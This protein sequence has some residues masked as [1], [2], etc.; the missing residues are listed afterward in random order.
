MNTTL[1]IKTYA[2]PFTMYVVAGTYTAPPST[3]PTTPFS[4]TIF[5]NSQPT[6]IGYQTLTAVSS[7]LSVSLQSQGSPVVNVNTSYVFSVTI[8]D[9]LTTSGKFKII[10]PSQVNILATSSAC[11]S[12]LGSG[13]ASSPICTINTS[14]NTIELSSINSTSS[15]I[16]AQP[17]T[18]TIFGIQNPSS[19]IPSGTFQVQSYNQ[20][21]D[22]SLVAV[23][24]TAAGVTATQGAIDPASVTIT[25]SS[26]K[27]LDQ[28]ATYSITL[29]AVNQVLMGGY[30]YIFIPA[31]IVINTNVLASS[32]KRGLNSAATQTTACTLMTQDSTGYLINF[33][34]P[35]STSSLNVGSSIT[36]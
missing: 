11:A 4:F 28:S 36:F 6:Q 24:T 21:T 35:L 29:I 19:I 34:T 31:P 14:T 7:T 23:G 15:A 18:L 5:R 30:F 16:G 12:M 13:L 26:Y 9:G 17:F 22:S 25:S 32:C 10:F 2:A 27:V 33:T 8:N 3:I 20:A 1:S